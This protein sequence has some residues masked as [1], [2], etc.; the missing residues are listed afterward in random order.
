VERR[1]T[2]RNTAADSLPV[3]A[4]VD[5]GQ[6]TAT[7]VEKAL[8]HDGVRASCHLRPDPELLERPG[9]VARQVHAGATRLPL[10]RPVHDLARDA[11]PAQGVGK[12]QTGDAG[13]DDQDTQRHC[14]WTEV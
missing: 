10:R 1:S 14:R 9:A 2:K 5:V 13:T 12:R 4:N 3:A 7:M 8:S 6:Q 11:A